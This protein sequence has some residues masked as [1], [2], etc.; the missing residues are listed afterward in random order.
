MRARGR[1]TEWNDDR[2]F[3]FV[4]PL[5]GGPR[6]FAHVSEFPRDK[7]RPTVLDL[8]E[9]THELDERN[10]PRATGVTFLVPTVRGRSARS[11]QSSPESLLIPVA[12]VG[13]L[14]LM[15]ILLAALGVLPSAIVGMFGVF[16]AI[17]F[18]AYGL[19]KAAA[20]RG[21]RRTPE[22]TLHMLALLGG[23]PG[24]LVA[25]RVY[26]HKTRKAS[27]Q[28]IFWLTVAINCAFVAV[29]AAEAAYLGG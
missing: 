26:H 2:G 29:F 22:T 12:I 1:L 9:Y 13:S 20:E 11:P 23:W 3:G 5:D 15:L 27:F 4:T 24:A 14:A 10:R 16:S 6:V 21:A 18:V 19:D 7:R 8:V 25:Q 28:L 17:A